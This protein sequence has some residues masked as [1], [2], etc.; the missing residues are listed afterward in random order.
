M[1]NWRKI[2][3]NMIQTKASKVWLWDSNLGVAVECDVPSRPWRCLN[4]DFTHWQ[5][6]KET[7]VWPP[8][9]ENGDLPYINPEQVK[10]MLAK[11]FSDYED[12]DVDEDFLMPF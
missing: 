7:P 12:I 4:S 1:I 8:A 2:K 3:N 9:L 10:E 5:V 11:S 6:S